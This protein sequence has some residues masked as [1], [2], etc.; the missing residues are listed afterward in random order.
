VLKKIDHQ[1]LCHSLAHFIDL[2]HTGVT[3]QGL[4]W[5]GDFEGISDLRYADANP[6]KITEQDFKNW[7]P[8]TELLQEISRSLN[9]RD[10]GRV[11][12]LAMKPRT[13]YSLHYDPDAWRVHIPLITNPDAFVFVDGKMWHLPVGNA[14][15]VKVLD[16][17]LALN[18]GT[19]IRMHV[20]FDYCANLVHTD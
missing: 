11:R 6:K 5:A 10:A 7:I 1:S 4:R 18:A 9:I 17:H 16:H 8:G 15:L 19:E 20:V 3:Q 14:Y 2:A 12:L 13:S